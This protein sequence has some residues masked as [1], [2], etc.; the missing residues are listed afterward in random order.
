MIQVRKLLPKYF[1]LINYFRFIF[2]TLVLTFCVFAM[3]NRQSTWVFQTDTAQELI[4]LQPS[5]LDLHGFN[6]FRYLNGKWTPL[7][8]IE[9]Q[10]PKNFE[11]RFI[12]EDSGFLQIDAGLSTKIKSEIRFPNEKTKTIQSRKR[13]E[14]FFKN[15]ESNEF[16]IIELNRYASKVTVFDDQLH[17]S[18]DITSIERLADGGTQILTLDNGVKIKIPSPISEN[19]TVEIL[20]RDGKVSFF[21]TEDIKKK[22]GLITERNLLSDS[23][24][25]CRTVVKRK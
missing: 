25:S 15:S 2:A 8:I 1:M 17:Y 10:Y 19:Q 22:M 5:L 9:V 24:K 13:A 4:V 14:Y 11:M 20:S 12:L 21:N 3:A 23:T 18:Y 16:L 6:L 7:N